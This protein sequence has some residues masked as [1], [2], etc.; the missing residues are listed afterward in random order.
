[1]KI[2]TW[3]FSSSFKCLWQG[4]NS[5]PN[6]NNKT[7]IKMRIIIIG[8]SGFDSQQRKCIESAFEEEP[9]FQA[10]PLSS[11][12]HPPHQFF[13]VHGENPLQG[14][15]PLPLHSLQ[16]LIIRASPFICVVLLAY[17]LLPHPRP[18]LCSLLEEKKPLCSQ[19]VH[20]AQVPTPANLPKVKQVHIPNKPCVSWNFLSSYCAVHTSHPGFSDLTA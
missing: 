13:D 20:S 6:L 5:E 8:V 15:D 11:P 19:D 17:K 18:H 4:R 12:R 16:A 7:V 14:P 10:L 1:M 2:L 3:H 9:T